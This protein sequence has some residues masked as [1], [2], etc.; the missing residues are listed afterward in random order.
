MTRNQFEKIISN[1]GNEEETRKE[2][3]RRLVL[4]KTRFIAA[5]ILIF[6]TGAVLTKGFIT[7]KP[8]IVNSELSGSRSDKT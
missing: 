2:N 6:V 8:S 5:I 7:E 1:I 4:K 3:E